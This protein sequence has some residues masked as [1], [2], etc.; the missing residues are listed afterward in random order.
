MFFTYPKKNV[1]REIKIVFALH[2]RLSSFS[3][4]QHF[5]TTTS[6]EISHRLKKAA[7]HAIAH[8]HSIKHLVCVNNINCRETPALM[9][10]LSKVRKIEK[11][12][13]T[14]QGGKARVELEAPPLT[15]TPVVVC[16][17]ELEAPPMLPFSMHFVL[18][19]MQ[20]R[21]AIGEIRDVVAGRDGGGERGHGRCFRSRDTLAGLA[22]VIH[23]G[24]GVGGD[25]SR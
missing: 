10:N 4:T 8:G 23:G 16:I 20:Q 21:H 3:T 7:M 1:C 19:L 18:L 25:Q 12:N 15:A 6:V 14:R 13:T 24:V 11:L 9:V 17:E 2:F 22:H 5:S